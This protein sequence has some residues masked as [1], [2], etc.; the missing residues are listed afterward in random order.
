MKYN[1]IYYIFKVMKNKYIY[2]VY[3]IFIPTM[4]YYTVTPTLTIH[5]IQIEQMTYSFKLD[6]TI[7]MGSGY[8]DL[9]KCT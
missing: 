2:F 6:I 1:M 9:S 8:I 7:Y 4:I 5:L 3:Y